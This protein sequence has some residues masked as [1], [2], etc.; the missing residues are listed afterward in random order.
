M[1]LL[2]RSLALILKLLSSPPSATQASLNWQENTPTTSVQGWSM[3]TAPAPHCA[4]PGGREEQG[5]PGRGTPTRHT[6]AP[7]AAHR[8]KPSSGTGREASGPWRSGIAGRGR[9]THPALAA[10]TRGQPAVPPH[11]PPPPPTAPTAAPT[12]AHASRR[13]PGPRAP[14]PR[15]QASGGRWRRQ[16]IARGRRASR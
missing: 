3:G 2:H 10:P 16:F 13:P 8:T 11:Q 7:Q 6:A 9:V 15:P 12:A 4:H 14:L 1:H 5:Q